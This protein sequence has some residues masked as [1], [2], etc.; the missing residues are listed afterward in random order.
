MMIAGV[1]ASQMVLPAGGGGPTY[2]YDS[3]A[4]IH[5]CAQL[6]FSG[7]A[8]GTALASWTDGS[9]NGHTP[10]QATNQRKPL[11]DADIGDGLPGVR[12][13]R[14]D[15]S[16]LVWASDPFSG[17]TAAEFFVVVKLD[18]D[19]PAGSDYTG[20]WHLSGDASNKSHFPYTDGTIYESAGTSSRKTVGNPT[21][22]LTTQRLYNVSSASGAFTVRLDTTQLYTTGSNTVGFPNYGSGHKASLGA[23]TL[24]NSFGLNGWIREFRAY[25]T[26]RS[27]PERAAIE[28]ELKAKW[29]LTGY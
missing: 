17:L 22:S 27:G 11:Y 28:T 2:A 7:V 4:R 5:L 14:I 29:G 3:A 20:L 26:I 13:N 16:H 25:A 18:A 6:G 19:P 10:A 15:F 9:G 21:P 24:S 1:A 8:D 12:F 23:E